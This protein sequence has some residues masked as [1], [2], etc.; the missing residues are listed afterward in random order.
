MPS[1]LSVADTFKPKMKPKAPR[2]KH[3]T[4]MI[5]NF[6]GRGMH[7]YTVVEEGGFIDMVA[8]AMPDYSVPSRMTFSRA[9]IPDLYESEK[10]KRRELQEIF[11]RGAECYSIATDG[12]I[13]RAKDR[14]VC[15]TVYVMD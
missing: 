1:Q 3:M 8:F 6:T 11:R 12:W 14:Y 7:P 4:K 2:A 9:V 5:G 15:V 13:S 10:G